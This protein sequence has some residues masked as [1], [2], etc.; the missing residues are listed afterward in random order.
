MFLLRYTAKPDPHHQSDQD[1]LDPEP[2]RT[3]AI[4]EVAEPLVAGLTGYANPAVR[5]SKIFSAKRLFQMREQSPS[6]PSW[7]K[8]KL[9]QVTPAS[10]FCSSDKSIVRTRNPRCSSSARVWGKE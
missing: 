9:V 3:P 4:C 10:A 2:G 8:I 7:F 5:Q 1:R 6:G